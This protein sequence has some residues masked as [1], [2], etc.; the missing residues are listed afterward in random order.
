MRGMNAAFISI[1]AHGRDQPGGRAERDPVGALVRPHRGEQRR[2]RSLGVPAVEQPAQQFR[3]D[4]AGRHGIGAELGRFV[5]VGDLYVGEARATEQ[6]G[7]DVG[8]GEREGARNPRRWPG[9]RTAGQGAG[10]AVRP[11]PAWL[12]GQRDE[13]GGL[14]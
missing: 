5:D 12:S 8:V 7:D 9:E 3:H 4:V 1:R 10:D 14:T 6:R 13:A 2:P 11:S